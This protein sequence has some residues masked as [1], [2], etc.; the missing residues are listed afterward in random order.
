MDR[1][2]NKRIDD[3]FKEQRVLKQTCKVAETDKLHW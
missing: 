2:K 3:G 1:Q